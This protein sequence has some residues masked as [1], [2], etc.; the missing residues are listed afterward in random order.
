MSVCQNNFFALLS[1]GTGSPCQLL[2][3]QYQTQEH[4]DTQSSLTKLLN[5][6]EYYFLQ[7]HENYRLTAKSAFFEMLQ[8][9]FPFIILLRVALGYFLFIAYSVLLYSGSCFETCAKKGKV[10]VH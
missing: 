7:N 1:F 8:F 9:L 5:G 4:L 6:G 3:R 2:Q 10:E